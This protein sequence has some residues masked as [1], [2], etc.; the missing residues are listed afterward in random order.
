MSQTEKQKKANRHWFFKRQLDRIVPPVIGIYLTVLYF[1]LIFNPPL[2]MRMFKLL[3]GIIASVAVVELIEI[4]RERLKK[5]R[6][7]DS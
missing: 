4:Y 3:V 7:L 1:L 6:C 5:K 2:F